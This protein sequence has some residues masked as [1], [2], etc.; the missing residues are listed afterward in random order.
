MRKKIFLVVTIVRMRVH[1]HL[2]L[3]PLE[4]CLWFMELSIISRI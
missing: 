2:F 4:V 1:T 3:P